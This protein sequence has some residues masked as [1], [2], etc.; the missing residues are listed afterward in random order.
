M[1]SQARITASR[2]NGKL[3]R[4]PKTEE[5]KR[6]S[7]QNARRHG[8]LSRNLPLD[9]EAAARLAE[10]RQR[11]IDVYQPQDEIECCLVERM[12]FF[13]FSH[14]EAMAKETALIN[15]AILAQPERRPEIAHKE[16]A[17]RAFLAVEDLLHRDRALEVLH[18][19]ASHH[20]LHYERAYDALMDRRNTGICETTLTFANEDFAKRTYHASE[21]M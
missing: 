10:Y 19:L 3:S 13:R 15:Q 6:R 11:L 18:R 4:G 21:K 16:P 5:G 2:A 14:Y 8:L 7:S 20:S 9:A 1:S 17:V 12:A